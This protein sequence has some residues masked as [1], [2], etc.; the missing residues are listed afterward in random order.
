M[1]KKDWMNYGLIG[2]VVVVAVVAFYIY[3]KEVELSAKDA[4]A[5]IE[6]PPY[7]WPFNMIF[8]GSPA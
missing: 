2:V 3:N 1:A 8:G 6:T 5:G 4:E 7:R